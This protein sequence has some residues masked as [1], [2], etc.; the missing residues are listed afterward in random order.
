MGYFLLPNMHFWLLENSSKLFSIFLISLFVN[1]QCWNWCQKVKCFQVFPYRWAI[2]LV[3]KEQ[4][5]KLVLVS[6]VLQTLLQIFICP[7]NWLCEQ[8]NILKAKCPFI[9]T[10]GQCLQLILSV[11]KQTHFLDTYIFLITFIVI[12]Q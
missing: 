4:Q 2:N 7:G 11:R 8:T 1:S 6:P 10:I 12:E 3:H 9:N 5:L